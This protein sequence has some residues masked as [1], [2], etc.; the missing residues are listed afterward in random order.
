MN[1]GLRWEYYAPVT[2]VNDH[3][4]LFDL[5]GCNGICPKGAPLEYPNYRN[6]DPRVGLAWAPS[7]RTAIR[8]GFGIYHAPAQNDDRNAALE[9]SD[10]R[11]SLTSADNPNISFPIDPF[12]PEAYSQGQTPRALYRHHRD[13]YA[14][15]YGLSIQHNLP[16]E[17][18]LGHRILRQRR[19]PLVRTQLRECYRSG[20]WSCGPLSGFDQVDIKYDDGNS[21]FNS[22]H[23][24]LSRRYTERLLMGAQVSVV[25]FH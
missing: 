3:V 19:A 5:Y 9:S 2:E 18:S 6:F 20:H 13:L 17:H 8:A 23:V 11:V 21:S 1:L 12:L 4:T 7:E 24:G 16:A 15:E 22:L 14:I 10:V 25:P